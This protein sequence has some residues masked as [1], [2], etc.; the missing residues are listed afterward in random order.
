[1]DLP[2]GARLVRLH[3]AHI[4]KP[5]DCGDSDLN[6]FF[7]PPT[8]PRFLARSMVMPFSGLRS[9]PPKR[10]YLQAVNNRG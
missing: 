8:I 10:S 3:T 4:I 6:D 2:Y 7:L 1:V 5:F 9:S